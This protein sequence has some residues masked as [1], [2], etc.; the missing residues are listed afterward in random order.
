MPESLVLKKG[1][2]L[3]SLSL[4]EKGALLIDRSRVFR[5]GL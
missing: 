4:K 2:G 3:T 1:V 5:A